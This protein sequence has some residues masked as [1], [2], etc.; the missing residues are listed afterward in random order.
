MANGH[1]KRWLLVN[2][3]N[4]NTYWTFCKKYS[5][6]CETSFK[7]RVKTIS[8]GAGHGKVQHKNSQPT[9]GIEI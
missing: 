3:D 6:A 1:G 5:D 9:R 8:G 7:A 4:G 2:S